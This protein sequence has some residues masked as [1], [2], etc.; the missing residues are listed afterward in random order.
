MK[1]LSVE[2]FI[3]AGSQFDIA[4]QFYMEIGFQI[5]WDAGDYVGFDRD[6]CKFILQNFDDKEFAQNLMLNV[7]VDDVEAFWRFVVESKLPE[8]FGIKITSPKQQPYGK[9]VNLIDL[10]GVCWHFVQ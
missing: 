9:E 4:K 5:V 3:P 7:K 6:G 10:A 1:F 2:P 8:R